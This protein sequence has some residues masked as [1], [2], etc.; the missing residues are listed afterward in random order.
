MDEIS[1]HFGFLMLDADTPTHQHTYHLMVGREF[2]IRSAMP[3]VVMR[4]L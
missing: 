2:E 4:L 3:R 1:F